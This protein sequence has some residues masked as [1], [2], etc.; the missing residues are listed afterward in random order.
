MPVSE[1]EA[2][3]VNDETNEST[4]MVT[5]KLCLRNFIDSFLSTLR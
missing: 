5:L 2:S 4:A 1:G 3:K